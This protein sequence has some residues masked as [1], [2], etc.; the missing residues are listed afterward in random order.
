MPNEFQAYKVGP[1]PYESKAT[2]GFRLTLDM[3]SKD[4]KRAGSGMD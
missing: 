1:K 3:T 2:N 4:A